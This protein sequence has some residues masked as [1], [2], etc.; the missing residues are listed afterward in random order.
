MASLSFSA[1]QLLG[2][3]ERRVTGEGPPQRWLAALAQ[4]DRALVEAEAVGRDLDALL[5]EPAQD[6][7]PLTRADVAALATRRAADAGRDVAGTSDVAAVLLSEVAPAPEEAVDHEEPEPATV[8]PVEA[9]GE[10][11]PTEGLPLSF[12]AEQLL[13][14]LRRQGVGLH[15][16]LVTLA[17]EHQDLIHSAAIDV[18]VPGVAAAALL[19]LEAGDA[20]VRFDADRVTELASREGAAASRGVIGPQDVAAALLRAGARAFPA[21]ADAPTPASEAQP[22]QRAPVEPTPADRPAGSTEERVL[23][24]G[25][26]TFRLFVSST[27]TDLQEERNAL[28]QHVFPQLRRLCVEHGARFQI[29]DLRWGVSTEAGLDQKT[30][31]LCLGEIERCQ[32]TSKPNFLVLLGDRY[33]W[34]PLPATIPGDELE[35]IRSC[36]PDEEVGLLDEWYLPDDNARYWRDGAARETVYYLRP[37][38]KAGPYGDTEQGWAAWGAVERQLAAVLRDAVAQLALP[39]EQRVEYL[40]SATEQEIEKGALSVVDADEHVFCFFRTIDGLPHDDSS[41]AFEDITDGGAETDAATRLAALKDRLS[42][43]VPDNVETYA[44][45]WDPEQAAPTTD[46]LDQL[47]ADVLGHLRGAIEERFAEG[48][49]TT[50]LDAEREAHERF[51]R[52]RAQVFV[53]RVEPLGTIADHLRRRPGRPLVVHGESGSGKSALV[54][55]AAAAAGGDGHLVVRFVG[56]TA[57]S[58]EGRSLIA[59]LCREIGRRYGDESDVPADY[60]ELVE[61]L[62]RRLALATAAEPLTLFIDALDQLGTADPARSL[63]WLPAQLPDHVAVVVSTLPLDTLDVLR[64]RQPEAELVEVEPMP[65]EEAGDLL[66]I[67]LAGVDRML[68]DDQRTEVLAAFEG[69]GLPLHLQLAFQEARLWRSS[70]SHRPLRPTVPELIRDNLFDRL[71]DPE[72]HGEVLVSRALGYLAASRYGLAEDELLS[73]LSEDDEVM[74]WIER[75]APQG[76]P[77]VAEGELRIPVVLWARLYADLEPYL[78]ERATEG[79]TVLTF[80]HRQFGEV[81]RGMY[82]GDGRG[83]ELHANLAEYFRCRID[84]D[85]DGT[86]SGQDL[87][88]LSELPYHLVEAEDWDGV[89]DVLTDFRFM[90]RKVAEVGIV[91]QRDARGQPSKLHTGVY[92]LQDDYDLALR[93]MGEDRGDQRRRII[94]TAVDLGDGLEIRCPHCN[95]AIPWKEEYR[96]EQ[97]LA[98]PLTDP[99]CGGPLKVN[100]FVVGEPA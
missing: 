23:A 92:R 34:R 88:G 59:N 31:P 39:E 44:A 19:R 66:D 41:A 18:D 53:G 68:G 94:V 33:G 28:H 45:A 93:A 62:P 21:D 1:E 40:A 69:Q 81:A 64:S 35:Q 80:Y 89:E 6:A 85:G 4:H 17:D 16:L 60:R 25:G 27:F 61:E 43:R 82:L 57:D 77:E 12:A 87:R 14:S 84:P 48:I 72:N 29:I 2:S 74:G 96:G 38:D 46:H 7:G 26:R 67:W 91:D 8:E 47:C 63:T 55:R 37:R 90:E 98:C 24:G 78:T 15:E 20:G 30:M 86:W 9:P 22:E 3:L 70:D 56:A 65:V 42:A 76:L 71:D 52:D 11:P 54:A 5:G 10:Q 75:E 58:S 13:A 49:A 97:E 79:A 73:V 99:D 50:P 32:Q 95:R 83:R 51:G 36:V 100:P